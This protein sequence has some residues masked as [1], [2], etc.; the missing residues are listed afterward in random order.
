MALFVAV[1]AKYIHTSLAIRYLR[2]AVGDGADIFEASVNDN[3]YAVAEDIYKTGHRH[4]LFACYIWNIENVIKIS[5]LLKAADKRIVISLGGPEVSH[6][7]EKVLAENLHI[8][9]IICGEGESGIKDFVENPPQR[10]VYSFEAVS[11]INSIPFPYR[12]GEL[13]KLSD[14]LV[15]YET[16]RGC[17]YNCAFCLSSAV[18]GVRFRAVET[19]EKEILELARSGIKLVKLVDRTFNADNKRALRLVEFIKAHT[20]GVTFHFEVK[21]ESM[22]DELVNALKASPKGMFQLEIGVQSTNSETLRRINRKADVPKLCRVVKEL[23]EN[24][25]IH[26]H[27]DLIAGLPKE[28][29][30]TFIKSFNDVYAMK[31]DDLQLGFLKKLSGAGISESDGVFS[32]FPPY[33]VISTDAMSYEDILRLKGVSR[34]IERVYNSGEFKA[35]LER[36]E[37]E[38]ETPYDMF[39]ELA[40]NID[41]KN[42]ISRKRIYELIY[43]FCN[44]K[45]GDERLRDSLVYDFC[46]SNRDYL[47][48]MERSDKAAEYGKAFVKD[49]EK[50]KGYF[51]EYL[52]M[53]PED[54]YKRLRF[55]LIGNAF[56]A[57]DAASKRAEKLAEI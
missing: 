14:R 43:A 45:F 49:D 48:F 2:N 16:S 19:V 53:R 47:S 4:I 13:E 9:H 17:P 38:Y 15:Y 6:N 34:C 20:S 33:E 22:S 39:D 25:N 54:R 7:A 31:P 42:P 36:L 12:K 5:K 21:A 26:L 10:G 57:F 51:P 50:L 27:L 52:G 24:E 8:D 30:K 44:K 28:D 32:D 40:G 23:H 18:K 46:I 29:I 37:K 11:D 35:T 41:F 1:N 3:V 55:E 56:Y